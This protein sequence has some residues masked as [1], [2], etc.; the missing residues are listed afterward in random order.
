MESSGME[1]NVV[2]D[3]ISEYAMS[4]YVTISDHRGPCMLYSYILKYVFV[5]T[6]PPYSTDPAYNSG[7]TILP[8]LSP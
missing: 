5:H 1:C 3:Y 6:E 8:Y 7:K 4:H 2:R